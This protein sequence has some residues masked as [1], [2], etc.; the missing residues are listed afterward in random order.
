MLIH[1]FIQFE[2]PFRK[3]TILVEVPKGGF[4]DFDSIKQI[5][6]YTVNGVLILNTDEPTSIYK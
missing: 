1:L 5:I 3:N 4:M 6:V 2:I